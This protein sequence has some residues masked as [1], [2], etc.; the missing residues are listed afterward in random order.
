M[1]NVTD[2]CPKTIMETMR[3]LNDY[4]VLPRLQQVC[5]GD[6]EG[7][8]FV[9]GSGEECRG[10][11]GKGGNISCWHC[12]KAKHTK[13]KCLD[14][15]LEGVDKGVNNLNIKECDDGQALF[16][17]QVGCRKE[18]YV[19]LQRKV[20]GVWGILHPSH[21]YIDTCASYASMPYHHLLDNMKAQE[22]GIV[23]HSNYGSA[24]MGKTR[25]LGLID[26]IWLNEGEIASIVPLEVM[27]KLCRITY[28]SGGG[29]HPSHF[30]I[31]TNAGKIVVKKN[32]KG[33]PYINLDGVDAGAAL[34]FV[35]TI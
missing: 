34:C 31:H 30:I 4:T 25:N 5:E 11:Q 14:L 1:T 23:G 20:K 9:Q 15:Q 16:S 28:N 29:M 2:N 13:N 8:A 27:A 35:Q 24:T 12:G 26:K 19:L 22:Q 6:G 3:V 10:S 32:K 33:M 17:T 7:M 18:C 21:L